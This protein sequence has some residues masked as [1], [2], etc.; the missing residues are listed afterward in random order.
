MPDASDVE[1]RLINEREGYL[2]LLRVS[3][4]AIAAASIFIAHN[5][6]ARAHCQIP[7]GIYGDAHRVKMMR[8]DLV[9]ITKSV[10]LINQL[11]RKGDAQSRNQLVR[12]VNNKEHHAEKIIRT[13]SD[14]F[15]AQKIKPGS[16]GYLAK[17]GKHHAVMVAAMKCKQKAD[18]GPVKALDK[19]IA[20]IAGYWK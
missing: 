7:C 19:A 3:L 13:I 6:S 15:M 10:K 14:Y 8:E 4:A 1:D 9:T 20:G 17:L 16:K 12:W 11:S 2:M 5:P 18:T